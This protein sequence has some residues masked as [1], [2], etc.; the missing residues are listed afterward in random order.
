MLLSTCI[1]INPGSGRTRR[2]FLKGR[3]TVSHRERVTK[4]GKI[5]G[6]IIGKMTGISWSTWRVV[7]GEETAGERCTTT[8][9]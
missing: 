6:Y 4:R 7:S 3:L 9:N 1:L 2:S 8:G 5:Q